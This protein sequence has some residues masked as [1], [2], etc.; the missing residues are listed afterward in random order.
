MSLCCQNLYFWSVMSTET[1]FKYSQRKKYHARCDLFNNSSTAFKTIS[2]QELNKASHIH[3]TSSTVV[4]LKVSISQWILLSFSVNKVYSHT[5][6]T[7]T[8]PCAN[9]VNTV[10][11]IGRYIILYNQRHLLHINPTGQWWSEHSLTLTGIPSYHLFPSGLCHHAA[12]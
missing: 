5:S 9:S 6:P 1:R 10:F 12:N 11:M 4:V 3:G 2:S 8:T 7:R